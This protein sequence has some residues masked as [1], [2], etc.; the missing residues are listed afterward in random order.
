MSIDRK[1]LVKFGSIHEDENG[2]LCFTG[3]TVDGRNRFEQ[4]N[5][6]IALLTLIKERLEKEI[7]DIEAIDTTVITGGF[8]PTS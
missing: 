3:F 8:N 6:S 4:T 5:T 2:R 7:A 1:H